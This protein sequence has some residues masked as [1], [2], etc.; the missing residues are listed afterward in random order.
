MKA[1]V[2]LRK[3]KKAIAKEEVG[4]RATVYVRVYV[5]RKVDLRAAT[6]ITVV[7]EYWDPML[8]GYK[9]D[10]PTE[11][12]PL[13][14]R[15]YVNSK[16]EELLMKVEQG[17]K[18]GCGTRWLASVVES[19]AIKPL[20]QPVEEDSTPDGITANEPTQTPIESKMEAKNEESTMSMENEQESIWVE[21]SS[22]STISMDDDLS[23][24][25]TLLD[26]F[27]HYLDTAELGSWHHQAQ[28]SVMHRLQRYQTW[29]GFTEN[30]PHFRLLLGDMDKEQVEDFADYMEHEHEYRDEHPKLYKS[31]NLFSSNN[32]R[33]I[34]KNSI[35]CEVKR[36]CMFLNWAAKQ[37]ALHDTSFR[38]ITC[39]QQLFGTPYY[40]TIE[41]R[42]KIAALD[43]HK[44]ARL[45]L[46]RNKFI[47]QCHVGCRSN[48]LDLFTWEHINGD[49][50]EY[51]PHKNLLAGRSQLVRVPLS[52]KAKEILMGIDPD[53]EYLFRGYSGDL[54]RKD[55][56]TILKMAGIDRK[57]VVYNP[58]LQC[59]ETKVL[60]EVAASH[61]ARRTFIGNLYKQVK[62]PSLIASLTGHTETSSSFTRYRTIDDEM[63]RDILKV[64][65]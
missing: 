46:H 47:F 27:Q 53:S 49:F 6:P 44:H 41:E 64:I 28:T 8:P 23:Q 22:K 18:K 39:D 61:L 7:T 10:T 2:S 32:I 17:Y 3:L 62:D 16:I 55:I 59:T 45:E 31:M 63:K 48:D 58:L 20:R 50:L 9:E 14:E 65:E 21:K 38:N 43:L 19:C 35:I 56:K 26:Y 52:E 54:Y 36:L 40:L 37:G 33:P 12:I 15:L 30:N 29:L 11:V 4:T 5:N 51:V 25:P 13:G 42:D 57:V 34:S 24:E 1:N 60:Y